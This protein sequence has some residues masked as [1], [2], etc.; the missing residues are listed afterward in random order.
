MTR[1]LSNQ[2][3]KK[4]KPT[5][6]DTQTGGSHYKDM[7]IQPVEFVTVNGLTFLEGSVI[8]RMCRHR[9][10]NGAEDIRKAIHECE[11]ILLLEYGEQP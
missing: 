7:A 1:E 6:L 3:V 8:K 9:N 2:G 10:K 4:K 5:A 11:L